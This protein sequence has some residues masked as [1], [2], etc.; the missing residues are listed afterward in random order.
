[1]LSL[2]IVEDDS[3]L[4]KSLSERVTRTG[5]TIVEANSQLQAI[6]MLS[7][8]PTLDAVIADFNLPEGQGLVPMLKKMGPDLPV[9]VHSGD[10]H[11]AHDNLAEADM[12]LG[13][14]VEMAVLMAERQRLLRMKQR[15]H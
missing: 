4:L 13:K 6:K 2:L 11:R 9:I 15:R 12:V 14:P 5:F 8:T 10:P 1:M 3:I 7:P